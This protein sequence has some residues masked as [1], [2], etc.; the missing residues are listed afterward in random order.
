MLGVPLKA[1][2]A[3]QGIVVLSND[4]GQL[5]TATLSGNLEVLAGQIPY[6]TQMGLDLLPV[7]GQVYYKQPVANPSQQLIDYYRALYASY[8]GPAPDLTT[9]TLYE[10]AQLS[11]DQPSGVDLTQTA[12]G[13]LW[14]ALLLRRVDGTGDQALAS[15]RAAL[16][17]KTLSLGIVP[18]QDDPDATL[19]PL[20]RSAQNAQARLDYQ[21]PQVPPDGS[22]GVGAARDPNYVSLDAVANANVLDEPGIVQLTLPDQA[23]LGYWTDIDPLEAGAGALPPALEDT[24]L[25]SR[26]IT[27]LRITAPNG[28]Q[29]TLLWAGINAA[30][31]S[32]QTLVVDEVLPERDRNTEPDAAAGQ[33]SGRPRHRDDLRQRRRLDRGRRSLLRRPRGPGPGPATAAGSPV[34]A[35]D[36]GDRLYRRSGQR[37]RD[38]W[39]RHARSPAAARCDDPRQLRLR[40]GPGRKRRAGIDLQRPVAAAGREGHQPVADLGRRGCG[41]HQ[42]RREPDPALPAVPRPPRQRR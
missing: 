32:Q 4:S 7:E 9:L 14:I 11:A 40:R 27:W 41:E 2:T 21:L 29:A 1:A 3:A 8:T 31:V 33:R 17:G 24:N 22:L 39:R 5:Q 42:R 26:L 20:G 35:A 25:A 6:R 28:G 19:S 37:H 16:A 34:A 23:G 10:T 12:D 18:V 15:A 38:V 13:S 30:S 36:A